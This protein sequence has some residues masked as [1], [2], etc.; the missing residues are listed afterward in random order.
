[1]TKSPPINRGVLVEYK[2]LKHV[3]SLAAEIETGNV[4]HNYQIVIMVRNILNTLGYK[5]QPTV[6]KTINS[7][8]SSFV[9]NLLKQKHSK[10]WDVKFHWLREN[11][12]FRIYLDKGPNNDADYFTK[13]HAPKH[14]QNMKPKCIL[15]G[16]LIK[17]RQNSNKSLKSKCAKVP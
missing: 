10:S 3:V 1:M 4:F 12:N 17:M 14:H 13:H 9:N 15:K 16:F 2:A 5:Q 8:A 6:V 7:T 11:E